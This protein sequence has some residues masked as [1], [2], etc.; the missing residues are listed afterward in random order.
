[1]VSEASRLS[2]TFAGSFQQVKPFLV[3]SSRK[4]CMK[5]NDSSLLSLVISWPS[6]SILSAVGRRIF[7]LS[8]IGVACFGVQCHRM[9]P[10]YML[11]FLFQP[12]LLFQVWRYTAW[13]L[14][15]PS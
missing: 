1:M 3:G 5:G 10:S 15:V 13:S 9:H 2:V 12:S 11:G 4:L 8:A 14:P 7:P 6:A